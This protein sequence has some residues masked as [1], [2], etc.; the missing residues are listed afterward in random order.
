MR[1]SKPLLLRTV[2][3]AAALGVG[4][5]SVLPAETVA[6][7]D[8]WDKLEHFAAYGVLAMLG[9]VAYSTP[10]QTWSLAAGLVAWGTLLELAQLFV[11]GRF[12]DPF[13]ALANG[14][15]AVAGLAIVR[16][17]SR[18]RTADPEY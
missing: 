4:A 12:C 9:A 11:P 7:V 13:D 17:L 2:F 3:Y 18:L 5:L 16:M 10:S 14:L 6:I 1:L 8:V 15:G